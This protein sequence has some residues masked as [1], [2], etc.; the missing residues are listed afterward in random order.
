MIDDSFGSGYAV[1]GL[2]LGFMVAKLVAPCLS[3]GSGNAVGTFAPALFM[4]AALGGS[5]GA[6]NAQ[7][8]PAARIAPGAFAM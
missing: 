1:A 8:P 2:L 6:F 5:C 7:L 3:I 4:G